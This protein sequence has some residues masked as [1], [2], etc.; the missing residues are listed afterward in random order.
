MQQAATG[1]VAAAVDAGSDAQLPAGVFAGVDEIVIELQAAAAARTHA[2]MASF[3]E[4]IEFW[5][6]LADERVAFRPLI[7]SLQCLAKAP[8]HAHGEIPSAILAA[9]HGRRQGLPR[10]LDVA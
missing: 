7:L 9:T 8:E 5:V 6:L 2:R 4:G 1:A 3:V 10:L